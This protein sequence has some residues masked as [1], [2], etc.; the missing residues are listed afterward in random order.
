MRELSNQDEKLLELEA[1]FED[2]RSRLEE[3]ETDLEK[4]EKNRDMLNKSARDEK[5]KALK[6]REDRNRVNS[7]LSE[8]R[9]RSKTIRSVIEE[10]E[11][12]IKRIEEEL[13]EKREGVPSK[14]Q[15]TGDLKRIEWEF[16]TTPTS[17][18]LQREKELLEK[19]KM[20]RGKLS[21][22]DELEEQ[23]NRRIILLAEVKALRLE[24]KR[25][26]DE[27][28]KLRKTSVHTHEKMVES[29]KETLEL[30]KKADEMHKLFKERLRVKKTLLKEAKLLREQIQDLKTLLKER[31]KKARETQEAAIAEKK[32]QI[33]EE[34][35]KKL[36]AGKKLSFE[37]MKLIFEDKDA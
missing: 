19:A 8:F 3:L 20:I 18:M 22:H 21:F 7:Q 30:R 34:T 14:K 36:E 32:R 6:Y 2:I 12:E 28:E 17:E 26:M 24:L 11:L 33:V 23:E 5:F 37:E 31:R 4:L 29:L 13:K 10:K 9:E 1:K 35:K 25:N 27:R 15:L 16:M